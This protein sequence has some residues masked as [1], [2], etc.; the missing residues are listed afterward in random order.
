MVLIQLT[1]HHPQPQHGDK[2]AVCT[3]PS[4]ERDF[5]PPSFA[6][7]AIP[8]GGPLRT[9]SPTG[10]PCM[11]LYAVSQLELLNGVN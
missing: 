6:S 10:R 3:V 8:S 1:R 9:M 5:L 2:A 4:A 7:R 11:V